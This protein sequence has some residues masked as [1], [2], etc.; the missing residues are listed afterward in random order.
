MNGIDIRNVYK[1]YI[2][3]DKVINVLN[4]INLQIQENEIVVILG[5]SGCGK[6]TLLRLIAGLEEICEGEIYIKKSQKTA[7]V[8]QEPRLMPWLDVR[9]NIT[10]GLSKNEINKNEINKIISVVG[11]DGFDKA[12]PNQLSG[13]MMQRV[14]LARAL[15]YKPSFIMMDEP[16]AAL[17]FFTR[18]Q[19]QMELLKVHN[20][21]KCGIV[22]VTHSID[23]AIFLGDKIVIIENGEVKKIYDIEK[24]GENINLLDDK[25]IKIK[26]DI[27]NNLYMY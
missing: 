1:K 27:I 22:F 18:E 7:F 20:D 5:K 24:D 17:D 13:G 2:V 26:K 12:Y 9:R 25:F 19:M 14:A 10:F 21:T 6:T 4:G 8:F 15:T 23:E 3:E 16:F 11:L